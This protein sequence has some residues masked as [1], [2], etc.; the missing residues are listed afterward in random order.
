MKFSKEF[1][2]SIDEITSSEKGE[3][4]VPESLKMLMKLL[5]WSS[6]KQLSLSWCIFQATRPRSVIAPIL[7]AATWILMKAPDAKSW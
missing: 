2:P 7:F 3:K 5:V 6:L 1:Y 4:W